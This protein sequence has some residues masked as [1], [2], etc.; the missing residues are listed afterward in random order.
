MADAPSVPDAALNAAVTGDLLARVA[1]LISQINPQSRR[2]VLDIRGRI[3]Q[4][5]NGFSKALQS[6]F[7]TV[8]AGEASRLN[9]AA[10][11]MGLRL[12]ADINET[13]GRLPQTTILRLEQD[14]DAWVIAMMLYGDDVGVVEAGYLDLIT[15]NRLRHPAQIEAGSLEILP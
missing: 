6:L 2:Q 3:T 9:R 10:R 4:A 13:I 8:F 12:I 14:A 1:P 7:E 5:L 11:E 15:R